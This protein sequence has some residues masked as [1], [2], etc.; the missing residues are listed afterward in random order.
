MVLGK[1]DGPNGGRRKADARDRFSLNM[2]VP[3]KEVKIEG[4]P[5]IFR[6]TDSVSGNVVRSSFSLGLVEDEVW[7]RWC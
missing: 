5:K 2:V 6:D 3:T 7:G 4:T 1:G